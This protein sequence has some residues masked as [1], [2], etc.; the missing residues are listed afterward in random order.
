MKLLFLVGLTFTLQACWPTRV[1]FKDGSV[2][3][4]WE[5][6]F[7]DVLE[8]NA[9]NAPISYA[10]KLT[11]ELKDA[12]QNRLGIKLAPNINSEAQFTVTGNISGYTVTPVAIQENNAAAKNRLTVNANFEV[13]IEETEE[14]E[15]EVITFTSTRF[16]D[17]DANQDLGSLQDDL[18]IEIN[19]QIIQDVLNKLTA[20]W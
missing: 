20:N 8:N 15:E 3:P 16:V 9:P 6:F 1:G 4:E 19:D 14:N 7:V 12:I 10:P 17:Y 5:Y 11:E 13:F 2:P 18:F